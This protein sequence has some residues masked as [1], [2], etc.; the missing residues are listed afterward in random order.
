MSLIL[1]DP[2]DRSN[3][4]AVWATLVNIGLLMLTWIQKNYAENQGVEWGGALIAIV[5]PSSPQ[6]GYLRPRCYL[7]PRTIIGSRAK[8]TAVRHIHKCSLGC[9]WKEIGYL[10]IFW[11]DKKIIRLMFWAFMHVFSINND[12]LTDDSPYIFFGGLSFNNQFQNWINIDLSIFL[13]SR[14]K[15]WLDLIQL[16]L[17][18]GSLSNA[19]FFAARCASW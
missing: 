15:I 18:S 1:V 11:T 17:I 13:G 7:G 14:W 19:S 9:N 10:E 6:Y 8:T 3:A 4:V 12:F 2:S 16:N 5:L